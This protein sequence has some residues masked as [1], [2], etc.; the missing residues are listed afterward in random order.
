MIISSIVGAA[1]A[2]VAVPGLWYTI[3]TLGRRSA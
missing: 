2:A 1:T 3:R